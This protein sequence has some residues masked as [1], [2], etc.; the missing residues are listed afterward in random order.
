MKDAAH[1]LEG[2]RKTDKSEHCIA[3][4]HLDSRRTFRF[5]RDRPHGIASRHHCDRRKTSFATRSLRQHPLTHLP[6]PSVH[7][8]R[9]KVSLPRKFGNAGASVQAL[10]DDAKLLG[11]RPAPPSLRSRQNRNRHYACPLTCQLTVHVLIIDGNAGGV[12]CR[13]L[14]EEFLRTEKHR[15]LGCLLPGWFSP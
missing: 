2:R 1:F 5:A 6:A 8:V 4:H 14:A 7:Q 15:R 9:V 13:T 3:Q 10:L 11:R 12:V